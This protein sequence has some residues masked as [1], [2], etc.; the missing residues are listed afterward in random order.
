M[1]KTGIAEW[2]QNGR[3]ENC[4]AQR[5]VEQHFHP[6]FKLARCKRIVYRNFMLHKTSSTSFFVPCQ[7]NQNTRHLG[8]D[9]LKKHKSISTF[10]D[11]QKQNQLPNFSHMTWGPAQVRGPV[12]IHPTKISTCFR[13]FAHE[14]ILN[15]LQSHAALFECAPPKELQIEFK[16][17]YCSCHG[18]A[19][20]L[21]R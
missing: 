19:L 7:N 8:V 4:R 12:S 16:N 1:H 21:H 2:L 6:P 10:T 5:S 3:A 9:G 11:F 20:I 17:Q 18:A 15:L 13:R 14:H